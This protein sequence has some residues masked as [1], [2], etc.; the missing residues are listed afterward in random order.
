MA[1]I[2]FLCENAIILRQ[3]TCISHT[4]LSDMSSVGT[5]DIHVQ[6]F[7]AFKD[8]THTVSHPGFSFTP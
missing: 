1:M 3:V 2:K 5:C 4:D 7:P 8:L 6:N